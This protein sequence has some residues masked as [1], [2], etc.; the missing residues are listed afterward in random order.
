METGITTFL[1]LKEGRKSYREEKPHTEEE[2]S[3]AGLEIFPG[4]H[5]VQY[6]FQA[7]QPWGPALGR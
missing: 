2:G 5:G 4:E 7:P 3:I 1:Q 6:T